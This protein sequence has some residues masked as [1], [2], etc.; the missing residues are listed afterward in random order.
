M[1]GKHDAIVYGAAGVTNDISRLGIP[2]AVY[3]DGPAGVRIGWKRPGDD[4]R[5]YY[6]TAFPIETALASS[7]N[8]SLVYDVT[9]AM[10]NE[11]LEYGGDVLLGPWRQYPWSSPLWP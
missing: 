5:T 11:T 4:T 6:A 1:I 7:W 9:A 8:T 2:A 3:F 10:G